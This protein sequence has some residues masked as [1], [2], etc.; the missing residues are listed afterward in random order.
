MRAFTV[1]IPNVVAILTPIRDNKLSREQEI[2]F[3]IQNGVSQDW[4]KANTP[5]TKGFG[6]KT[7]GGKETLTS[8]EYLPESAFRRS[9][10]ARAGRTTLHFTKGELTGLNGETMPPVQTIQRIAELAQPFAIGRDIHVGDDYRHQRAWGLEQQPPLSSKHI[11]LEN[12]RSPKRNLRSKSKP[13][14]VWFAVARRTI[15]W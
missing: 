3:L 12:T 9:F 13:P 10:Q 14:D 7:V 15:P 4:T 8:D 5:S 11:T 1:L 2:E 6:H